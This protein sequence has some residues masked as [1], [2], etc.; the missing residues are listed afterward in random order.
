MKCDARVRRSDAAFRRSGG[1]I[2]RARDLKLFLCLQAIG[3]LWATLL[4]STFESRLVA[5]ALAGG[6]F[7]IS[8]LFMIL[9]AYTWT[10]KWRSLCWYALLV[11][12][13]GISIPMV[14]MR[15]LQSGLGFESVRIWGIEGPV[16]HRLSGMVFV[17]LVTATLTDWWRTHK[18]ANGPRSAAR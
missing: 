12:V 3:V 18:K 4:F 2:M 16:F 6:F 14:T 15:F 7:V 8:G 5:G 13:F 9:R 17:I 1:R 10:G 11:H